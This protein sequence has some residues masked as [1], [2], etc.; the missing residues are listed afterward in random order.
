MFLPTGA[1]KQIKTS[2]AIAITAFVF[3]VP[4]VAVGL[5][6]LLCLMP[7][8][9]YYLLSVYGQK[10]GGFV[11][12]IAL[13]LTIGM[14]LW[15]GAIS[16]LFFT[17]TLL[18]VGVILANADRNNESAQRA[19]TKSIGYLVFIWLVS[20][21]LLGLATQSNPYLDLRQSL[22]KGFETT[23]SLYQDSG[24]F[25]ADD[26][27]T[28]KDFITQLREQVAQLFPALLLISV[29]CTVWLNIVIGQ[30]LLRKKDPSRINREDFKNWR[31]PELLVWLVILTGFSLL[32]PHAKLNTLSLNAG[33]VLLVLYLS[34]GLAIVSSLMQKWSLPLV[35]RIIIYNL[36]FLQIYG[37]GFIAALG[38]ADVWV[39]FRKQRIEKDADDISMS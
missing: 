18:P 8:P 19:G 33:L 13:G 9:V 12:S 37:I 20:G 34:Q 4:T 23:F 38:L 36:L 22:D 14:T 5:E 2:V 30:W 29:I 35:V 28:I 15:T 26:L 6:W 25:K 7:L 3:I 27:A 31:L 39:D 1:S 21:W 16:G 10:Q 17:L 24:R 11:I 32:M